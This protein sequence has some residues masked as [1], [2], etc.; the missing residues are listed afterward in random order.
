M[1]LV[2]EDHRAGIVGGKGDILYIHGMCD[3]GGNQN[4]HGDEKDEIATHGALLWLMFQGKGP[5]PPMRRQSSVLL[6]RRADVRPR[7]IP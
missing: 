5:F 4:S 3:H 6:V 1:D 2:A 7:A